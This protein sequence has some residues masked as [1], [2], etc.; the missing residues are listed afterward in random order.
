[1]LILTIRT[2]KPEAE[3]GLYDDDKQLAYVTWPAHRELSDIIHLKLRDLL[4]D[5]NKQLHDIRGIVF[6]QG[7]GS[8]TG[9][10]IGASVANALAEG[11]SVAIAGSMGEDWIQPAVRRLL[12][13]DADHLAL[14]EYGA[15]PNITAPRK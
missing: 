15:A 14:P 13:G 5:Q 4:A 8:F 6:F 9:L 11:V 7:P 12:A 10:R 1:M 3:L 2:D